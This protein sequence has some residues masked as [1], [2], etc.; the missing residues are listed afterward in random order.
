MWIYSGRIVYLSVCTAG[1]EN[2]LPRLDVLGSPGE[3]REREN[4]MPLRHVTCHRDGWCVYSTKAP[5]HWR[6]NQNNFVKD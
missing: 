4:K 3:V 1:A 6:K 5:P 2:D